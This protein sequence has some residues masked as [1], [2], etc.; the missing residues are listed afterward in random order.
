MTVKVPLTV[1]AVVRVSCPV[2]SVRLLNVQPAEPETEP[3]PTKLTVPPPGLKVPLLTSAPPA[4][5]LMVLLVDVTLPP[6]LIVRPETV[7]STLSVRA[8]LIWTG[9]PVIGTAPPAHVPGVLALPAP[10]VTQA[11]ATVVV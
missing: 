11:L 4:L 9:C 1:G 5:M 8:W 6:P 3:A 10:A 2:F 7:I